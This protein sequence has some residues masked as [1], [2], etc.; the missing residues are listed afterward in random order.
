M[1]LIKKA[2][3]SGPLMFAFFLLGVVLAVMIPEV[4]T[5]LVYVSWSLMLIMSLAL[6]VRVF[7]PHQT[8]LDRERAIYGGQLSV[9]PRWLRCWILDETDDRWSGFLR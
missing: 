7:R 5:A 1:N 6:L 8:P 2:L 4:A 3:H 9:M